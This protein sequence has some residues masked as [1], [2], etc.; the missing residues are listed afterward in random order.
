MYIMFL[1]DG[2]SLCDSIAQHIA[3]LEESVF[4]ETV[5]KLE[6]L[7]ELIDMSHSIA[8]ESLRQSGSQ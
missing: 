5:I 8:L 3:C 7:A 4:V 1:F 6:D 2:F